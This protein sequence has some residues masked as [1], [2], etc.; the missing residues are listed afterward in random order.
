[1]EPLLDPGRGRRTR[2]PPR[3]RHRGRRTR[4][5]RRPRLRAAG[6]ARGSLD[7]LLVLHGRRPGVP[8]LS[9]GQP[10]R[11]DGPARPPARARRAAP[12][13]GTRVGARAG[14]ALAAAAAPLPPDAELRPREAALRRS[15]LARPDRA[16]PALRDTAAADV[17]RILRPSA[18]A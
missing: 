10:A 16:Q 15:H 2:G 3:R 9:V 13:R 11:G 6:P 12:A 1:A 18:P 5:P 14:R 7:P 4:R 17:D 8:R